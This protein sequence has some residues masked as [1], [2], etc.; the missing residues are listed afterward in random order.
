MATASVDAGDRISI[1]LATLQTEIQKALIM[2]RS[3][4]HSEHLDTHRRTLSGV[5]AA[6]PREIALAASSTVLRGRQLR[7][8]S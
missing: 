7:R 3:R 8:H 5:D 6:L 2:R 4:L 1:L